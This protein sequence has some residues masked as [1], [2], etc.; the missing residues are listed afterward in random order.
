MRLSC[1]PIAQDGHSAAIIRYAF[2]NSPWKWTDRMQNR[3]GY[4]V[5]GAFGVVVL[6]FAV[7]SGYWESRSAPRQAN[8]V[9]AGSSV[10]RHQA[11]ERRRAR[12]AEVAAAGT[13]VQ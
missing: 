6:C 8:T 7:L 2:P 1:K 12:V 9:A 5:A 13:A 11:T 3:V 4:L 10:T